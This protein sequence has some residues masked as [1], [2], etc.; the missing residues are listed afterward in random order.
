MSGDLWL[1][2][3]PAGPQEELVARIHRQIESFA[4]HADVERAFVQVELADGSRFPLDAISP[5]PGFGF[6]TLTPHPD[7]GEDYPGQVIVPVGSIRRIE[8]ARAEDGRA[9]LGFS[10]PTPWRAP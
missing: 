5:G 8:L 3:M 7:A 1:P 6:V 9:V 4:V 2:G 10:L